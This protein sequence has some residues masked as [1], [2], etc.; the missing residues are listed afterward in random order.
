MKY[1]NFHYSHSQLNEAVVSHERSGTS[2]EASGS[3]RGPSL[4][5]SISAPAVE[6]AIIEHPVPTSPQAPVRKHRSQT[7][8]FP[9][10]I[11]HLDGSRIESLPARR[12]RSAQILQ[13]ATEQKTN[14]KSPQS[15]QRKSSNATTPN[16]A[17]TATSQLVMQ[18]FNAMQHL[19]QVRISWIKLIN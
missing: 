18:S 6:D 14:G 11:S 4:E 15:S 13:I 3:I 5:S 1:Y 2:S 9:A 19:N 10:P 16:N 17:M 12:T 7:T 8:P